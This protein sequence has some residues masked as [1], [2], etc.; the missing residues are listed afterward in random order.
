MSSPRQIELSKMIK[1]LGIRKKLDEI[2]EQ[3]IDRALKE[4]DSAQIIVL[5]EQE[6]WTRAANE[7]KRYLAMKNN[8]QS[9]KH[10]DENFSYKIKLNNP[11]DHQFILNEYANY[12]ANLK[13]QSE[14]QQ[15]SN[16][17]KNRFDS[18]MTAK[19]EI[20]DDQEVTVLRFKNKADADAFIQM[21]QQ[22]QIPFTVV[23]QPVRQPMPQSMI[24]EANV[25]SP[26]FRR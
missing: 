2:S 10:Y 12:V 25:E 17:E 20:I 9:K 26:A 14:Y 5:D 23:N 19:N 22:N 21:L 13:S 24:E 16:E 7:L 11:E 1:Q 6:E 15:S 18:R 3:D 8:A 4:K